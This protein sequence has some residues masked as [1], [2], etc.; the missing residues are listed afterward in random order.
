MSSE[1][2]KK[3]FESDSYKS[4]FKDFTCSKVICVIVFKWI[5]A[6]CIPVCTVTWQP[7]EGDVRAREIVGRHFPEAWA[8]AVM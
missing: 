5:R 7:V 8:A 2:Y 1:K 6:T 4:L 3:L